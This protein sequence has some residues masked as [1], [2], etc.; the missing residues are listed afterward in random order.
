MSIKSSLSKEEIGKVFDTLTDVLVR[1][2]LEM[3]LHKTNTTDGSC[4]IGNYL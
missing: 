2:N 3:C 4:N 1:R